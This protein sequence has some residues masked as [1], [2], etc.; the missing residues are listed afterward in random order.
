MAPITGLVIAGGAANLY[1]QWRAGQHAQ[2]A[3]RRYQQGMEA[4]LAGQ[5]AD[6]YSLL[7]PAAHQDFMQTDMAQSTLGQAREQLREQSE[8]IRGGVARTGGTT[9]AAVA[10]QTATNRGYADIIS[11]LVGHGTTYQ[12]QAR[13]RLMSALGTLGFQ[14]TQHLGTMHSLGHQRADRLSQAG[15]GMGTGLMDLAGALAL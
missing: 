2:R 8:R 13:A 15:Q 12:D 14:Q 5:R 6:I 11:R 1:S 9:E 3:D 10:G 7:G 4:H